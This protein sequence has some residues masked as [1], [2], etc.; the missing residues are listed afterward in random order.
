VLAYLK[1]I[2]AQTLFIALGSPW[3]NAY[4]EKYNSRMGDEL[5]KLEVFTSLTEAKVLVEQYR[6]TYNEERPTV[7]WSI[8]LQRPSR[9][10]AT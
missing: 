7:R 2:G 3:E 1:E 4:S 6:R 8:G 10:R 9:R 5:L